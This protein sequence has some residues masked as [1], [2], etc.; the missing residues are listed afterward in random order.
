MREEF[1]KG[2]ASAS[3]DNE[4]D[5][6]TESAFKRR[7]S[8]CEGRKSACE[9]R[10][11]ACEGRKS[12]QTLLI[13]LRSFRF[14]LS[15]FWNKLVTFATIEKMPYHRSFAPLRFDIV[16]IA[17]LDSTFMSADVFIMERNLP[18]PT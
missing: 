3:P 1:G 14:D 13:L 11:S 12:G 4:S 2:C 18:N 17:T 10:K 15:K 7:K 16:A 6:E 5:V 8:A 9:D